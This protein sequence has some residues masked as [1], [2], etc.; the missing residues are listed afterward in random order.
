METTDLTI[1]E[2]TIAVGGGITPRMV[3]HY[4]VIGLLP[5]PARST[6]NYRLY[7]QRSVQQLKQIV[8][9]K[10]QGFQL[11]HIQQLLKNNSDDEPKLIAQL[12]QQYYKIIQQ[13][14]RLRH[15]ATALEGILGRDRHGQMV[16]AEV[17]AELRLL[18]VDTQDGDLEKLWHRL[19]AETTAYPEVFEESLQRLLPNLSDRSE[20]EVDLLSKLVLACGDVSLVQFVRRSQ[21][22]I[23]VARTRLRAGCKIVGDVRSVVAALDQTRLSHLNCQVETLINDLHISSAAEAEQAF[24]QS[25]QWHDCL[26]RLPKDCVLVIGY[27]PSVL[28]SVC[29]LI[30]QGQIQP[31]LVIGMPIGFSH[32]PAAKRQLMRSGIPYITIE[33]TL[34]GGLLAAVALN[35]LAESLIEQPDCHC[36]LTT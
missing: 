21:D 16:Q 27:A 10:Q 31:A 14:T 11:S 24:W 32:A 9:L 36:H 26:L 5:Q 17:L 34:G 6:S 29:S 28:M 30:E 2:L 23:A 19:D 8:A 20:L 7:G 25:Q 22:A 12:Q 13:L 18:D 35:A 33:G 3:R 1:K 4:H 15:T